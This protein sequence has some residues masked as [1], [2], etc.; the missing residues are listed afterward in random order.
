MR[1]KTVDLK[2]CPSLDEKCIGT[3]CMVFN[4]QFERCEIGLIAYNLFGLAKAIRERAVA[5]EQ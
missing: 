3:K 1:K 5:F 2:M 4:E